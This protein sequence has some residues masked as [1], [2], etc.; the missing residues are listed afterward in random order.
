MST[1]TEMLQDAKKITEDT[2]DRAR[3]RAK[4]VGDGLLEAGYVAVGA[5]AT[6]VDAG[7]RAVERT[8]TLPDTLETVRR[9]GPDVLAERVETLAERGRRTLGNGA[10]KPGV[11]YEDR[12]VDE[13]R[14]LAGERDIDGRSSMT[15]AEL[16]DALRGAGSTA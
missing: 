1:P 8:R 4:R 16:I 3:S 7:R 15:K 9:R 2:G 12:T 6:V 10:T 14:D 13:L 5:G 11:R